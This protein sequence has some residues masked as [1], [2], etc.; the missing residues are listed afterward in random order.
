MICHSRGFLS[1]RPR[2]AVLPTPPRAASFT[3]PMV[4]ARSAAPS[5]RSRRA[6][7]RS[8]ALASPP[9]PARRAS[10]RRALRRILP[11]GL[12]S[13]R[14]ADAPPQARPPPRRAA[15]APRGLEPVTD[16][17]GRI[18]GDPLGD[19][20]QVHDPGARPRSAGSG[21]PPLSA[22]ANRAGLDG[23]GEVGGRQP[24][25]L[26]QRPPRRG[27]II[28]ADMICELYNASYICPRHDGGKSRTCA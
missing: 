21:I 5:R 14:N 25:Q 2:I 28:S 24:G 9:R 27:Q 19:P 20:Q 17:P 16:L 11:S 12:A 23:L 18:P 26:V 10:A 15:R 6:A 3:G 7:R 1:V 13:R 22:P 8:P 4:P